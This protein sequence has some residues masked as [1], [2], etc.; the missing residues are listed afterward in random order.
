LRGPWPLRR[1]GD[2]WD[3]WSNQI[4]SIEVIRR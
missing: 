4:S 1:H 2:F 3:N